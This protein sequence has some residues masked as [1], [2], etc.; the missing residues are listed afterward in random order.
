M[1]LR[2]LGDA[3]GFQRSLAEADRAFQTIRTETELYL[4]NAYNGIGSVTLLQAAAQHSRRQGKQ[5]LE[6]IDKALALVPNHPYA[7]MTARRPCGS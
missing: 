7:R 1:S 2:D 3:A 4:S 5:A 6:W